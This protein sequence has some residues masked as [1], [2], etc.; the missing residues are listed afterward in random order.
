MWVCYLLSYAV[1][2]MF[3]FIVFLSYLG[4]RWSF[5]L[6]LS[7]F[8]FCFGSIFSYHDDNNYINTPICSFILL[9]LFRPLFFSA[10]SPVCFSFLFVLLYSLSVVFTLLDR[11]FYHCKK[12]IT[13]KV[14]CP[15]SV[16]ANLEGVKVGRD[17]V[18]ALEQTA[19]FFLF[20]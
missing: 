2:M 7:R 17:F 20:G 13:P 5:F 18:L 19:L 15:I 3:L 8:W 4:F 16:G 6:S 11:L 1:Y 12:K 10:S 14:V 9:N